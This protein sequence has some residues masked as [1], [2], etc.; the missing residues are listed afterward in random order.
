MNDKPIFEVTIKDNYFA[1]AHR[2]IFDNM[3][4]YVAIV[5][6]KRVEFYSICDETFGK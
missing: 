2:I 6:D 5:T 4:R 1:K 3:D